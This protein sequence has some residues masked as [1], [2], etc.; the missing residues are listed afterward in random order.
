MELNFNVKLT[1]T[2]KGLEM[3]KGTPDKLADYF[4]SALEE[5]LRNDCASEISDGLIQI[6][7]TRV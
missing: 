1:V 7:V 3:I 5:Y 2:E 4:R 6:D